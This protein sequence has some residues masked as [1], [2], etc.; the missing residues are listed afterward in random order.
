MGL[1]P[2]V[3]APS[4]EGDAKETEIPQVISPSRWR[5]QPAGQ[6]LC[7]VKPGS[8]AQEGEL[9][10]QASG[11]AS[12]HPNSRPAAPTPGL[13]GSP[14]AKAASEARAPG[15][16][17]PSGVRPPHGTLL[18]APSEL[19]PTQ[20]PHQFQGELQTLLSEL[21]A[22]HHAPE[23][24]PNLSSHFCS[25]PNPKAAVTPQTHTHSDDFTQW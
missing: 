22:V 18:P 13:T 4:F 6:E 14:P 15:S 12:C 21:K 20:T 25:A 24:A 3:S 11:R 1:N 9:P 5:D 16:G 23:E 7:K 19:C 10:S 8:Q 17:L 2:E